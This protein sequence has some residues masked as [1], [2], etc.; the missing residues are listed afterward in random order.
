MKMN[1][2]RSPQL[3]ACLMLFVSLA[4]CGSPQGGDAQIEVAGLVA[5][6]SPEVV[7]Q[8][9]G[10]HPSAYAVRLW[11]QRSSLPECEVHVEIV[12]KYL[13]K[14]PIWSS[15]IVGAQSVHMVPREFIRPGILLCLRVWRDVEILSDPNPGSLPRGGRESCSKDLYQSVEAGKSTGREGDGFRIVAVVKMKR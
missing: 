14:A 12:L 11:H 5:C 2:I 10:K 1:W 6:A 9:Q 4:A 13:N 15:G 7:A 3:L 8:T